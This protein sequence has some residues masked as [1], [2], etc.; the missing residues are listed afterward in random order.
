MKRFV[1][2]TVILTTLGLS[3][4]GCATYPE[5]AVSSPTALELI[6][7]PKQQQKAEDMAINHCAQ[8]HT[9]PRLTLQTF[10]GQDPWIG[11]LMSYRYECMA[12]SAKPA[13]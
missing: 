8:S 13:S 3:L 5:V 11:P 12:A 7:P 4:G 6:S 9:I 2:A 10:A 1:P